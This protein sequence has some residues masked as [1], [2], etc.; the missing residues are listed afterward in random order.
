[1]KLQATHNPNA[2]FNIINL[3]EEKQSNLVELSLSSYVMK[4]ESTISWKEEYK[5]HEEV[6]A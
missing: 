5:V 6:H 1:M 2:H 4:N 3:E